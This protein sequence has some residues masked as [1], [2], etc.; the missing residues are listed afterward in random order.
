MQLSLLERAM[1][2][3]MLIYTKPIPPA[4]VETYTKFQIIRY[5]LSIKVPVGSSQY[6]LSCASRSLVISSIHKRTCRNV[7]RSDSSVG[8]YR[9]DQGQ[10]VGLLVLRVGRYLETR[11]A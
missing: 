1:L 11:R 10:T 5:R 8:H 4:Q 7:G 2:I 9:T 6:S 3:H